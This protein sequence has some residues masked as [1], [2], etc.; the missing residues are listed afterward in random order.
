MTVQLRITDVM[1]V[2]WLPASNIYKTTTLPLLL[3]IPTSTGKENA[4]LLLAQVLLEYLATILLMV[5]KGTLR[6]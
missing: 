4:R 2:T 5:K 3:S 6:L 1:E